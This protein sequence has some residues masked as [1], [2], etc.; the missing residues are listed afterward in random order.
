MTSLNLIY[1]VGIDCVP[2][3]NLSSADLFLDPEGMTELLTDYYQGEPDKFWEAV[4][5]FPNT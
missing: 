3:I 5:V 1:Y 4:K 2:S